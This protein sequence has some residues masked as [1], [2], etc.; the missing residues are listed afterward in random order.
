M[1]VV[2]K[3]KAGVGSAVNDATRELGGTLG[4]AV[5]GS[6][7]ASVYVRSLESAGALAALPGAAADAARESVGGALLAA[8]EVGRQAAPE[9]AG[10]LLQAADAAFFRS[11]QVA[12]LIAGFVALAGGIFAAA[13]L[14]ARPSPGSATV[15]PP[16]EVSTQE[17]PAPAA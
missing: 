1:G 9:V 2:P 4:V 17:L 5:I 6:I 14:P 13:V 15:A 10:R 7:S 3:D 8:A 12:C 11:L 16:G